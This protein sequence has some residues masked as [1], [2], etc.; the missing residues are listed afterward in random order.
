VECKNGAESM[1]SSMKKLREENERLKAEN[2]GLNVRVQEIENLMKKMK[3]EIKNEI[4]EEIRSE[5]KRQIKEDLKEE[6]E[7]KERECNVIVRGLQS[8]DRGDRL[9]M[10]EII[11]DE[12]QIPG[13]HME[14]V[15]RLGRRTTDQGTVG[16]TAAASNGAAA[17]PKLLL[18]KLA[19]PRQKWAIIGK[20]KM[21]KNSQN[22]SFNRVM[23]FP[24]LSRQE[25]EKDYQLRSELR[26]RRQEGESNI[27]I[28][29]GEIRRRNE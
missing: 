10:E 13:V 9:V 17:S 3:Q 18:V 2:E 16:E 12:L 4:K 25:R 28:S 22:A 23:I 15:V 8:G 26:R 5:V 14:E 7:K 27:Y 29:K 19:T 20:A 21:L 1:R 24:D 6:E 11:R